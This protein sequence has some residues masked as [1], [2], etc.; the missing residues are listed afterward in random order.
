MKISDLMDFCSSHKRVFCYGAGK[1]GTTIR[2]FLSEQGISIEAFIVTRRNSRNSLM[3]ISV[4]TLVEVPGL[5]DDD[6]GII[7]GVGAGSRDEIKKTLANHGLNN[8]FLFDEELFREVEENTQ[9][10]LNF[11]SDNNICVLLYHRVSK[12]PI[13]I[14][15]LSI[16]PEVFEMHIRFFKENY[17]ILR[18][19]DDWTN[20]DT[21]SLV[22]TFDDGYADNY[23]HALPILE[24]YQVPATIF[25]STGNLG[26][27]Q[28]FWWDELE[29]IICLNHSA[30]CVTFNGDNFSLSTFEEQ[31]EACRQIR[32][33]LKQMLPDARNQC[34][35]E[36]MNNLGSNPT[37]RPENRSLTT[38]ELRQLAQSPYI[39]IGGHTI[40]HNML[41]A[42]PGDMQEHEIAGSKAT[43]EEILGK[44]ITTFSYP[45]GS[46]RDYTK[47]TAELVKKVGYQKAATT[48]V[49]L[50]NGKEDSMLIP[51]NGMPFYTKEEEVGRYLRKLFCM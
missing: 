51:R 24:K 20:V 33:Q 45:F 10:R 28:E 17:N 43:L 34:L 50:A 4:Y 42:E 31:K 18:F 11:H 37:P 1:Y 13:D 12:L 25:V 21:P 3:G 40:T 46:E 29:R 39:T 26:T 6:T 19:E 47:K 44:T 16:A 7:V 41:S 14:W 15:Q 2:A 32:L 38:K 27:H 49:G 35:Q 23:L 5:G 30:Q 36:L 22:I 48:L 9:Y 8:Y